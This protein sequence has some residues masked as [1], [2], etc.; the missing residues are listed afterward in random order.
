MHRIREFPLQTIATTIA[1][2]FLLPV[3]FALM[4]LETLLRRG[5]TIEVYARKPEE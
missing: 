4:M 3:A 5:G 1:T 2:I